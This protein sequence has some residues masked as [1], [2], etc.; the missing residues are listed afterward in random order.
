MKTSRTNDGR[1]TVATATDDAGDTY[2]ARIHGDR[3]A[4]VNEAA[5]YVTVYARRA[6]DSNDAW[7]GDGAW[8]D[9]HITECPADLPDGV[10]DALDSELGAALG[11]A[12]LAYREANPAP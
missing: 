9:G 6:G 11:E 2:T 5:Q 7:A 12:L 3:C 1:H 8:Y 4:S 10:Y